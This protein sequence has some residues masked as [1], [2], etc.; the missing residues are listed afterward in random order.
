MKSTGLSLLLPDLRGGGAERISVDLA[1]A[2]SDLGHSVEF[3]LMQAEGE[4][5]REAEARHN[6]VNLNARRVRDVVLP[7]MRH[8]RRRPPA[9]LVAAMWPLTTIG[10]AA[11]RLAGF[12]GPILTV[13]H[14]ILSHQYASWGSLHRLAL[15]TSLGLGL[16][17][18]SARA[19]VSRGAAD[20]AARLGGYPSEKVVVLHNPI[21]VR[22]AADETDLAEAGALWPCMAGKRIIAVGSFKAVKNH[23]LLLQAFA[24]LADPV[25]YLML[26]G[27]GKL[28]P[29]LKQL[30]DALGIAD[31]VV[32]AGFRP[33]PTPFYD[34]ANLL[35]LSSDHEALPTVLIEAVGRGLPVVSTDCPSGPAEI[36]E[37][38]KYGR[39][40]PVGDA[41]ALARA[42]A[43]VLEQT[44]DREAL[45]RRAADFAPEK[46][47]RAYL[48]AM[49]LA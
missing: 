38:G 11:A 47:A 44:P 33:D 10:P 41:E 4:F 13:E 39:L 21:P 12:R 37:N 3:L 9:G 25:A 30:A 29:E 1:N 19:A 49:G 18:A 7:L 14:G 15:R 34:T 43:E 24:H 36:L 42:M 2:F 46:A 27:R 31:R 35:V 8:L 26:V 16:R 20:D 17:L 28:E 22:A 5:L 40:T 48:E 45:K 32:F 23:A 6:I